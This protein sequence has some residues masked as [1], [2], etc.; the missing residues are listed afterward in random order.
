MKGR[1]STENGDILI[2]N[3]VIAQYAGLTAVE[4]F[5]IVGMATI[6]VKD[7]L[8]KLLRGDSVSRV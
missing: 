2:D 4:C 3:E 5:G 6:S 1:M 8:V 7:G